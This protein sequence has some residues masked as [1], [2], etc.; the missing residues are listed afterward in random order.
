MNFSMTT[1]P[2]FNSHQLSKEYPQQLNEAGQHSG[3][4]KSL[5]QLLNLD[6]KSNPAVPRALSSNNTNMNTSNL[7]KPSDPTDYSNY[8]V[9]SLFSALAAQQAAQHTAP[10]APA[11]ILHQSLLSAPVP[12]TTPATAAAALDV[13]QHS[14][15]EIQSLNASLSAPQTATAQDNSFT[16]FEPSPINENKMNVLQQGVDGAYALE[17]WR[18]QQQHQI[19][20]LFNMALQPGSAANLP[21]NSAANLRSLLAGS[22]RSSGNEAAKRASA[23]ILPSALVDPDMF[24]PAAAKKQRVEATPVAPPMVEDSMNQSGRFRDY[25]SCQWS[26]RFHELQLFRKEK[27]HCCV[28][29]G[30]PKNIVLAR[31][32]KRQRYQYKLRAEGKPSTMTIERINALESIGFIW[33]SHG[34]C[35]MER[36]NELKEYASKHG[37]CNISSRYIDL[38]G[39]QLSSWVKCQRRLYKMY[40]DNKATNMTA[41]RIAKLESI[42]FEWELRRSR[43]SISSKQ[44]SQEVPDIQNFGQV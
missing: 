14:S 13:C 17:L 18:Q 35:W 39:S 43:N 44:E 2:F 19:Q 34:A 42:G 31:W 7:L 40:M 21:Q 30:Y 5:A 38:H 20:K 33:D 28:P 15:N 9:N 4:E 12:S 6:Y 32:V 41:E 1:E 25:Q 24:H 23:S 29:H 8:N 27:G 11:G 16:A 3:A 26:I 10:E 37:S 36:Y 22:T